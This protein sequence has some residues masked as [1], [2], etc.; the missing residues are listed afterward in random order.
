MWAG[1]MNAILWMKFF[2]SRIKPQK[3]EGKSDNTES[4]IK[5][6][7]KKRLVFQCRNAEK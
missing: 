5:K 3:V 4:V 7:K 6:K 2:D 1:G